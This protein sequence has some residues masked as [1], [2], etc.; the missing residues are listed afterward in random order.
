MRLQRSL[1]SQQL[2]VP[3]IRHS[4]TQI[5][6]QSMRTARLRRIIVCLGVLAAIPLTSA[7]AQISSPPY[8]DNILTPSS[9]IGTPPGAS[10]D[11]DNES[12]NLS[13]SA[14]TIYVPLLSVPQRGG[15]VLP[16][17]LVNSSN[18]YYLQQDVSGTP[19]DQTQDGEQNMWTTSFTYTVHMVHPDAAFEINLP[20]LQ[21]SEEYAG[22]WNIIQ[23]GNEL[24]VIER[25]CL[26]NFQFTDWG[27]SKHPFA[28]TQSC[29]QPNLANPPFMP[30]TFA[31]ATDGSFYRIDVT[32][33]ADIKVI[34]KS[35]TVYHFYNMQNPYPDGVNDPGGTNYENWYDQRMGLMTDTNGNSI[36]V[37]SSGSSYTVTDTIGRTFT[38]TVSQDG[39]SYTLSYKGG[40]GTQKS[41]SEN[42]EVTGTQVANVFPPMS[43]SYSPRSNGSGPNPPGTCST[44]PS[45]GYSSYQA[46][47]TFPAADSTGDS[48]KIVYKLDQR[49]RVVEVDYPTGGYTK[50]DYVDSAVQAWSSTTITYYMFQ[51]LSD[52]RECPSSTGTCASDNTTLYGCGVAVSNLG[53]GQP[54]CAS[55]TVTD[56]MGNISV[57]TFSLSNP[58]QISPK[59]TSVTIS[60]ANKNLL[61]TV[62]TT[63]TSP[64]TLPVNT[65][66]YFPYSVTTTL[67]DGQPAVSSTVTYSSYETYPIQITGGSLGGP[68]TTYIDNPT[69]VDEADYDGTTKRKTTEQWEPFGFFS[70]S[71]GHILDRPVSKTIADQVK[72][73]Q[74]S[75]TFVYDNGS[76]TNGNVTQKTVSATNATSATTQYVVNGYGEVTQITDPDLHVTNIYY[77][78][79]WADSSCSIA[80]GSSA[81]PSSITNAAN[82]TISYTYNTCLGTIASRSGPN[83]K[84]TTQYS[85]DA[86][87]RVV[88]VSYPDGGGKEVCYFDSVPN[89]VTTYTLQALGSSFPTCSKPTAI[90]AG[91]IANSVLLDGFGRKEETDLLSDP[92]GVVL[93]DTAYDPNGNVQSVSN[94]YRSSGDP[95][96]GT[97]GYQYDALRRKTQMTNPDGQTSEQWSYAG[98]VTTFTDE[99]TSQWQ[100]TSDVFGNLTMVLEP[101]GSSTSPSME[102]DYTYDGLGNLWSVAQ[103]GG[104]K[105]SSGARNRSFT[106]SGIS[107]LITASNPETGTVCYG[108]LNGSTCQP[109]YDAAGNLKYRTDARG[110]LT[111]YSYDSVNRL[112]GKSYSD[113]TATACF[114]YS[115]ASVPY[116]I[117]MLTNEWTQ[118][119]A[120]CSSS[121][122]FLT[123]RSIVAFDPMGRVLTEQQFTIANQSSGAQYAPSF[124]YDLAGN[125]LT[126]DNGIKSTPVVGTLIFASYFDD[127]GRLS[128]VT[129]N[130]DDSS[131]PQSLFA[132]QT[133]PSQD[134]QCQQAFS[135]P[136]FPFGGLANAVF[137]NGISLNRTY[138][139]RLR[140]TCE[141]DSAGSLP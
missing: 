16:F 70:G 20:R 119:T 92:S 111:T 95:T 112:L 23:G 120:L 121:G 88:S 8:A 66:L 77:Q 47:V 102:T 138:D 57:H 17:G 96:Y 108:N 9:P 11:G 87:Q 56:P 43:C 128:A 91:T 44:A 118:S 19:L 139:K 60:D 18:G 114:Q 52:K 81:Y 7:H 135:S 82:E 46:T 132:A 62:Q 137:G 48:R 51:N 133:L 36:S 67:N 54:Y 78:D 115:V 84:Q 55:T 10:T 89:H 100:R 15:W 123:Q 85:Y 105:N 45:P 93:V 72:G 22:S 136:Y 28:L 25:S 129:S 27:G 134:P 24:G 106:Y 98:N 101:N 104:A 29:N 13:N 113:G 38:L 103:W 2:S 74:N 42:F 76:N 41:I 64:G 14:L 122:P 4:R 140:L 65:D 97:T 6:I 53:A 59:E 83:T 117:G 80:S 126:S 79:A 107:Q 141:I 90:Q 58:G 32:N 50:Y 33:I 125:I 71:S 39:Q 26:T 1:A 5:A 35:G 49:E 116:S 127:A 124:I 37:A 61:R 131:H 94:P 63:Y 109:G 110:I 130:W 68:F 40:D 73:L 99:N 86:L 30:G 3:T 12:V 69:E 21:A 75:T 34:S 31:D